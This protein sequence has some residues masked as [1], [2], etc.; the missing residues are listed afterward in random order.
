MH[1]RGVAANFTINTI[2]AIAPLLVALF[3]IPIYVHAVGDARYGIISIV[4]LLLGYA[5]F[6]DLGLARAS[7]NALARSADGHAADRQK[8]LA[9][10]FSLNIVLGLFGAG[11]MYSSGGYLL[12]HVLSAPEQLKHEVRSIIPWVSALFP[13]ALMSGLISGSLESREQFLPANIL[14]VAG[15]I[16]GQ[17][18]PVIFAVLVSPSLS[19]VIPAAVVARGFSILVS[20]AY[21]YRLEKPV[22]FT[23]FDARIA[24]TL[25]G[26][27]GWVTVSSLL[28]PILVSVDQLVIGSRL[29]IASVTYYAVPMTLV[30][31]GQ[32]F[33]AAT[34]R[35]IFPRM[36]R[37]PE[38]DAKT[39]AE[40]SSVMLALGFAALC[41]PAIL[42]IDSLLYYWMGANFSSQASPVARVLLL[43]AWIN[44]VAFV[45]FSFLQARARP[46]I[47]A[48]I[49]IAE[50]VPFITL[51]WFATS[52]FGL[53]GAASAWTAR[54]VVDAV[55]ML[56]A[57]RFNFW[58]KIRIGGSAIFLVLCFFTESMTRSSFLMSWFVGFTI[59]MGCVAYFVFSYPQVLFAM[60]S[61]FFSIIGR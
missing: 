10:A 33:A 34:S 19:I 60:R 18:V 45:P 7:E 30:S 53:I 42:V 32:L 38:V 49:H 4:W 24:R 37:L 26:Y 41:G 1:P 51:L 21:V 50:L 58:T 48:K 25:L 31:R 39:L 47:S 61:K 8:V 11:I 59:G 3:T 36:S 54:V 15:A 22:S 16:F 28:S 12:E 9:T 14:N 17:I 46:D 44:G 5:G 13:L 57:A 23:N 27:G 6:L 20:L 35:T 43:G 52:Y 29:G 55:L 56:L 2:G 40:E